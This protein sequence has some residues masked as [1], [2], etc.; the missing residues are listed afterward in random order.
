M[1]K[2][3]LG[4]SGGRFYELIPLTKFV[5]TARRGYGPAPQL[6]P[7]I[8][9]PGGRTVAVAAIRSS[10]PLSSSSALLSKAT[11]LHFSSAL[12]RTRSALYP[13]GLSIVWPNGP[14]TSDLIFG[15]P[16]ARLWTK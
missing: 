7:V 4:E 6:D 9:F 8:D 2:R 13:Y 11:P 1:T 15:V 5:S 14:V 12:C 10:S 3:P 16:I